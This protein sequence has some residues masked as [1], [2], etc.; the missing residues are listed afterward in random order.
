MRPW[1]DDDLESSQIRDSGVFLAREIFGNAL[2]D[3]C[4]SPTAISVWFR[5]VADCE[6]Q[7]G[8]GHMSLKAPTPT[9][10]TCETQ[11][12]SCKS[13]PS[14]SM[15]HAALNFFRFVVFDKN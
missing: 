7:F 15:N 14:L 12:P 3:G 10:S 2:L 13:C 5:T 4:I 1:I 11:N 6:T 9:K 8:A